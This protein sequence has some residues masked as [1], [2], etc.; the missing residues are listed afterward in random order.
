[1]IVMYVIS[2]VCPNDGKVLHFG[3]VEADGKLEQI[4]GVT[5]A[6]QQFL[7]PQVLNE[8]TKQPKPKVDSGEETARETSSGT[9][10]LYHIILY[11]APGDYHHFHS[12]AD[13]KVTIRR[14]FPGTD[15]FEVT[16][17]GV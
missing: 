13:W 17:F 4:K 8:D 15:V 7:G 12:P 11:L 14:H 2:Q 3:R 9:N 6:L 5:Y 16:F 1:M 10:R